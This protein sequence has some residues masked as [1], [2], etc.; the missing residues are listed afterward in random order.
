MKKITVVLIIMIC[1]IS[2]FVACEIDWGQIGEYIFD[3]L[4]LV[5][6]DTVY[7]EEG[8]FNIYENMDDLQN[9]VEQLGLSVSLVVY[10]EDENLIEVENEIFL[11]EAGKTYTC[12]LTVTNSEGETK[13]KEF[14]IIGTEKTEEIIVTFD[15][16]ISQDTEG[17]VL[18]DSINRPSIEEVPTREGWVFID[19]YS[20]FNYSNKYDFDNI[21]NDE[22]TIYAKWYELSANDIVITFDTCGGSYIEPII[23]DASSNISEP[24]EPDKEGH[25][26]QGWYSDL[27]CT[28]EYTFDS[29]PSEN[30]TLYAYWIEVE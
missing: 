23:Q 4:K 7:V 10:D 14:T 30:L 1:I 19:W 24:V 29:M 11:V 3:N 28:Q 16:G 12:T 21:V 22:I 2:I 18:G 9:F 5:I 26:F 6:A 15:Y 8:E 13:T 20:E 17:A 25:I 27:D